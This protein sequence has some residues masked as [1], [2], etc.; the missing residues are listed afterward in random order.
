MVKKI[1]KMYKLPILMYHNICKTDEESFGLSLSKS[2]LEQQFKYLRDNGFTTFHFSELEKL[3]VIPRKSIVLTFDDVTENQLTYAVPL[4]EKHNL[5]ASFFIPFS[6]IGKTDLWNFGSEK[7]MEIN[8][9]Q[10]LNPKLI[11]LGYHSFEHKKYDSMSEFEIQNDFSEC[12]SIIKENGLHL[13]PVLA[14][15]YGNYPKKNPEKQIFKKILNKNGIK[16]GLKI[17]N[18]PNKFPFKD[19]YEIKRI[20][21]KG[22]D[23]FFT[24]RLKLKFGKLKL[25]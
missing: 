23:G 15:P 4:L 12:A 10:N 13:F 6:Y 1:N 21:M 14:Y 20:D 18:R 25:F 19:D 8:Q 2:K 22:E 9:L 17:G 3:K 11:E 16:F 5:K 7:I 24:F